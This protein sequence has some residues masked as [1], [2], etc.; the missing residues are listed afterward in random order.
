MSSKNV[1]LVLVYNSFSVGTD[2]RCQ[3]LTSKVELI[4]II[5]P[6]NIASIQMNEK[7]LAKTFVMISN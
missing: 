6:G 3:N 7:E 2:F 1:P 5:D 4:M